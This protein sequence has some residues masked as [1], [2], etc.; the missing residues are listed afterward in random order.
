MKTEDL[1]KPAI[2]VA[3]GHLILTVAD[4][5]GVPRSRMLDG[6]HIPDAVI[7]S[8]D[9]RLSMLQ[10][11][12][13]LYRGL[14]LTG[15][16]GFG[17]EIGLHSG[18]TTHGFL[19]Y[20]LLSNATLRTAVDFG[21]RFLALRLPNLSLRVF[22]DGAHGVIEASETLALG[23]VRQCM[24]DLFL[25]GLWRMVPVLG[26]QLAEAQQQ[27]ELWFDYPEPDYAQH[28]RTR[29]PALRFATGANQVRFPARYLD[30]PL[31][32]ADPVT[33]RLVTHQCEQ[34]LTQ[35][36]YRGDIA[37]QVRALLAD[38]SDGY[39]GLDAV[40][41]RLRIS[42]RTLKRRLQERGLGFQQL[43]DE[44]RRR[45]ALRLLD[46]ATLSIEQIALRLGYSDPANFTRAFR[47]WAGRSPSAHRQVQA[48]E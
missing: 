1:H 2:P 21:S 42:T 27:I 22:T 14:K 6:L 41:A 3:Y 18:L 39:P 15:N 26:T 23:A 32:T 25:V 17:Y 33:A 13:L 30:Q 46:D 38:A 7:A 47:K 44:A 34:E 4:K 36:G 8:A 9:A 43:L 40:A 29:L 10:A 11:N 48:R 16:P 28:Y 31:R 37:A 24:Y 45:D 20:G 5:L 35:L 19:G 12:A